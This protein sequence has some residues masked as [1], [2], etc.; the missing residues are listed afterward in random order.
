MS[1]FVI[2]SVA[3]AKLQK[4]CGGT[5][6]IHSGRFKGFGAI[7]LAGI[8][9]AEDDRAILDTPI[10][11]A[12]QIEV[13]FDL[14][15]LLTGRYTVHS[16]VL[17]DFLLTAD[18]NLSEKKWNLGGLSF[19]G[20]NRPTGQIPLLQ[21]QHGTVRVRQTGTDA[22]DVL[23][24]IGINGQI[25]APIKKDEYSFMLETDGRFGF[26]PSK[27]AGSFRTDRKVIQLSATGQIAMPEMGILQN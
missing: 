9:I 10:L 21:I 14:W 23:A 2:P 16:I 25:G 19:Q 6:D 3:E 22:A 11:Q 5:V 12:D 27:L 4:L 15:H 18:Y 7:R 1:F 24:T 20:A 13:Q 8:V 17:S 26:G